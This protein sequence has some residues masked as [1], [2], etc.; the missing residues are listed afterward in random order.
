MCRYKPLGPITKLNT[1]LD[2]KETKRLSLNYK[3]ARLI[4]LAKHEG[5]RHESS[6]FL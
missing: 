6:K 3:I 2:G 1:I 4:M 5:V